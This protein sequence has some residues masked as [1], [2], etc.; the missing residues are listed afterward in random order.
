MKNF[1]L[2]LRYGLLAL[3]FVAK[4]SSA[5][6]QQV[7]KGT[8]T[9]QNSQPMPGVNVIIKGTATGTTTD[10]KGTFA[11]EAKSEDVLTFS[12][13]G[14]APQEIAV[15]NQSNINITLEEDVK[16]PGRGCGSRLW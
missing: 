10:S 16:P 2:K 14:Y 1:Y 13:I 3:L 4:L 12:F 6:G 7:V 5:A 11:I 8:V 9:D 15:G